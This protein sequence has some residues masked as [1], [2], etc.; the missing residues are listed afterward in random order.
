MESAW[1]LPLLVLAATAVL[2]VP[3]GRYLAWIMDGR[4]RPPGGLRWLEARLNT[5]PQSWK[6]YALSLLV[7]ETAAFI[8]TFAVLTLQP[9][10]P[11]NPDE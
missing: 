2:S 8:L 10:L 7:F 11:L 3:V 4:Y 9:W 5:G 6:E 1:V